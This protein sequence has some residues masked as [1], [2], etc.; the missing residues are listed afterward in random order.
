MTMAGISSKALNNAPTNWYKYNGKEEQRQEF[1]DGSG[2]EWL[3][4][5]ARMYDAQIGRWHVIDPMAELGRRWSP[6]NYAL[7]NPLRFI[8]PDGMWSYDAN[9]NASTSNADE[10][11]AF[12][13]MLTQGKGNGPGDGDDKKKSSAK[14]NSVPKRGSTVV[15]GDKFETAQTRDEINSGRLDEGII[16]Q[17]AD[18]LGDAGMAAATA[19][20]PWESALGW[21]GKL[22]GIGGKSVNPTTASVY[23]KLTRY[24]LNTEHPIGGSKAKWFKEALGYTLEN[25]DD[26]A[27]QIVFDAGKAV[28]T[29]VT[30]HGVLYNQTIKVTGANGKVI[31]VVFG[32]IKN[33]DGVVRLVTG[34]PTKL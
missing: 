17:K 8:D 3:D 23:D 16:E 13:Q 5:G 4:Y 1:S 7:N 25:M 22:L 12:M 31:D 29:E 32:W 28:Q 33:N 14:T 21:F 10:I 20:L 30:K 9:G 24:L 2:L 26:L 27:K 11:K 6:Y 18:E 15:F 19:F 34:I